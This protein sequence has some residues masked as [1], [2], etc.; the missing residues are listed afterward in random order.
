MKRPTL[1]ACEL[2]LLVVLSAFTLGAEESSKM[3]PGTFDG[4]RLRSVGPA[5]TSGRIIDL[6]VHPKLPKIYYAAAA[7]GGVWKTENAGTTWTPLFDGEKSFS[8]GTITLD[9][10]DP[11]VVWVGTGENNSQR[12]V[13]YGDGVY[14]SVDGGKT[15]KNLGLSTSEHIAKILVDPRDSNVV[16]VASQGPLWKSGGERGLFKTADGG[17]TWRAVLEVSENT[18]ITDVTMDPR[19]PDVLVAASYQRRRHVFTLIDGG[20]ESTI[21]KTTDGGES[22]RLLSRVL[23]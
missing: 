10:N 5:L 9:P 3:V 20:P 12:S 17:K 6:A 7:S 23:P 19:N 4:L 16:Y 1:L 11:L 14:K 15:W 18:G 13:S 2:L 8:I 22:F 21:Y